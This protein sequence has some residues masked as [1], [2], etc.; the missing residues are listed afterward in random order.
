MHI[1]VDDLEGTQVQ[2]LLREHLGSMEH[3]APPESR[4]ALDLSGLRD[5]AITFWSIWDGEILAGFGAL[6]HLTSSH[7][8]IKSMR[9]AASHMRRGVGSQMLKHLIAEAA[10][11]GYTKISL[12]TGSMPFFHPARCLYES[13][14]F[15][16]CPPFGEYRPDPNSTFMTLD[17]LAPDSDIVRLNKFPRSS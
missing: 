8:E 12:E 3:T 2:A 6:K 7:A 14:G 10:A 5:P 1:R 4:H 9:T 11:R 16:S 17:G 15:V 13:F